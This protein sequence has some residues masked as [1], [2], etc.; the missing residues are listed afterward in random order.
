MRLGAEA[1]YARCYT[2][3]WTP[4]VSGLTSSLDFF[5]TFVI[6]RHQRSPE[7]ELTAGSGECLWQLTPFAR[8][9]ATPKRNN[10]PTLTA[11]S[12]GVAI[13]ARGTMRNRTDSRKI[14]DRRKD[15]PNGARVGAILHSHADLCTALRAAGRWIMRR[16]ASNRDLEALDKLRDVSRQADAVSGSLRADAKNGSPGHALDERKRKCFAPSS[17]HHEARILFMPDGLKNRRA[18]RQALQ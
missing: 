17:S 5:H 9:L 15:H 8:V 3:H 4:F 16:A 10:L 2:G 12:R 1:R 7:R 6:T 14:T 18:S 13:P 11:S